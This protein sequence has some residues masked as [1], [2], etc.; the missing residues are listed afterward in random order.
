MI[1]ILSILFALLELIN[2]GIAICILLISTNCQND[3]NDTIDEICSLRRSPLGSGLWSVPL[4]ITLALITRRSCLVLI[5]GSLMT[6]VSLGALYNEL[7]MYLM[8]VDSVDPFDERGT[9]L[10]R[11]YIISITCKFCLSSLF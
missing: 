7:D 5:I 1:R 2:V 3:E 6:I 8:L 9:W 10:T 4:V 11:L